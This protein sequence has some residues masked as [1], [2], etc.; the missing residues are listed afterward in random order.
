MDKVMVAVRYIVAG[1][2]AGLVG[3]GLANSDDVAGVTQHVDAIAGGVAYLAAFGIALYN[4][5][6]ALKA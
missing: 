2:G 4:K 6:K 1:V 5:I 3:F